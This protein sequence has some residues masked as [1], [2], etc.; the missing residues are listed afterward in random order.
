MTLLKEPTMNTS[1]DDTQPSNEETAATT[2]A[3]ASSSPAEAVDTGRRIDPSK[4]QVPKQ[5][6][7][8]R[9]KS[10][11]SPS[12]QEQESGASDSTKAGERDSTSSKG[13]PKRKRPR[14]AI[15][16]VEK[17]ELKKKPDQPSAQRRPGSKHASLRPSTPP[18]PDEDISFAELFE[19]K[20]TVKRTRLELGDEIEG[21]IIHIGQETIFVSIQETQEGSLP[22]AE[23]LDENGDIAVSVGD[24][25]KLYVV[26]LKHGIHLSRRVQSDQMSE[27]LLEEAQ[28][29]GIPVSGTV[30]GANKGG[31]EVTL[32]GRRAFCPMGQVALSFVE[33]PQQFVGQTLDFLIRE[34]KEGGRNIVLSRRA[35]LE[36]ERRE[37][38]TALRAELKV[39]DRR[40]GTV[41]KL[42]PFGVFVDLGGLDGLIPLRELSHHHV[43]DASEVAREGDTL[44]VEVLSISEEPS[45]KRPEETDLKISLSLKATTQDPWDIYQNRLTI[46][47]RVDGFVARIDDFGAFVDLFTPNSGIT[48][49]LHISE[50]AN[51]RIEA[52]SDVLSVNDK[53]TLTIKDLDFENKKISL[54]LRDDPAGA[55]EANQ[56]AASEEKS[57]PIGVS[58]GKPVSGTVS[59]IERYGIFLTLEEG[60]QAF[61]HVSD[62][63][64]PSGSDLRKQF[65]MGDVVEA[66]IIDIDER[67]RI[68]VSRT[69]FDDHQERQ[70]VREHQNKSKPTESLGTF[71]DL[72]ARKLGK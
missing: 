1:N 12:G 15:R 27:A 23:A 37:K 66:L 16:V 7:R 62:T 17:D 21:T 51:E 70:L 43:S 3:T 31:L 10:K 49:L 63:G 13:K 34:I 52:V 11:G 48:G 59:R 25:L 36:K 24:R 42:M 67:D 60:P 65:S 14:N 64:T 50:I 71:A 19:S 54:R 46:G 30:A 28:R 56:T 29:N 53:K 5:K 8:I 32:N 33:D 35:L 38:A 47:A 20:G 41:S 68:K 39:G 9:Q 22:R 18:P 45:K 4:L 72:F 55:K 44:E 6:T 61:M 2:P 57:R 58:I 26:S 40:K 69:A